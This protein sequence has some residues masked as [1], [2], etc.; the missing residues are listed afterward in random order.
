M[1][2]DPLEPPVSSDSATERTAPDPRV[3]AL[4]DDLGYSY[5]IVPETATFKV[6][7]GFEDNRTQVVFIP[8]RTEEF[9][10]VKLREI[11]SP[12]LASSGIFDGRTANFLLRDNANLK[13]G[14]LVHRNGR[15]QCTFRHLQRESQ[16]RAPRPPFCP[17]PR[18]GRQGCRQ[19]RGATLRLRRI[20]TPMG[21]YY[22]KS[23]NLGPFRVNLNKSGVGYSV[24]GRG[25]RIGNTSWASKYQF[26]N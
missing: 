2:P 9:L 13:F 10:G 16:R 7:Y 17:N 1:T 21:F 23:V 4:L 18:T 25:F 19:H 26:N 5:E 15:G 24:G 11:S 12:A 8:S 20:L 22:R 6:A 14:A 3:A